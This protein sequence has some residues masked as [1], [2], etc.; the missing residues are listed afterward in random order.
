[1]NLFKS[2]RPR[3]IRTS[4]NRD[5]EKAHEYPPELTGEFETECGPALTCSRQLWLADS[6]D[7][8]ESAG[9]AGVGRHGSLAKLSNNLDTALQPMGFLCRCY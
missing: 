8:L 2:V 6:T 3:L 7:R 9:V 1:M 4:F 5:F